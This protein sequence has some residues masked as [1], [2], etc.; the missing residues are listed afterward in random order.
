MERKE[1]CTKA[2]YSGIPERRTFI[3]KREGERKT[4][5]SKKCP[6]VRTGFLNSNLETRNPW[7]NNF[8]ILKKKLFE[9][10]ILLLDK[11]NQQWGLKKKGF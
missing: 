4:K 6:G 3:I 9:L 8:K 5:S 2:R 1:A 10:A 11:S 7:N